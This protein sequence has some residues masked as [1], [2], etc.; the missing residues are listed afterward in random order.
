M[1]RLRLGATGLAVSVLGYRC[2]AV[3]GQMLRG[4]AP[5]QDRAIGRAIDHGIT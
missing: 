2:G 4:S 3:G 5:E 1:E